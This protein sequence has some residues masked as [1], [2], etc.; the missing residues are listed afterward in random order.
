MKKGVLLPT[1]CKWMGHVCKRVSQ[2]NL[3]PA[4]WN[5]QEWNIAIFGKGPD[6]VRWVDITG[7]LP[8][9]SNRNKFLLLMTD[10]YSKLT[11][12]KYTT[13][14]TGVHIA[15]MIKLHWIIP[16]DKHNNVLMDIETQFIIKFFEYLCASM[17][18]KHLRTTE[19]HPQTNRQ[20][21]RFNRTIIT[22]LKDYVAEHQRNCKTY[23]QPFTYTYNTQ[24]HR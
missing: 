5:G 1:Y 11:K 9:T 12:D 7:P 14:R 18:M 2:I 15:S 19:Y 8:K 10:C 4:V 21:K 23:V 16:Y 20:G 22:R 6:G 3:E 24:M 13:K 17:G